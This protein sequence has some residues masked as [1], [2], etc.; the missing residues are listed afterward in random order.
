MTVV[1]KKVTKK[2]GKKIQRLRKDVGY[3]SQEKFAEALGLSRTHIGHIE[4]GRKNPSMEV[5]V[6]IAKKL[7]V[8]ISKLFER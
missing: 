6:K 7:K 1:G 5:L 2:L 8:D 3:E 4:Q